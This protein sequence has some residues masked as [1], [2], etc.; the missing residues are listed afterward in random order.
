MQMQS[1][2]V[3]QCCV[4]LREIDL[5]AFVLLVSKIAERIETLRCF[6]S[7]TRYALKLRIGS[8]RQRIL[9]QFLRAHVPNL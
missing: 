9:G 3:A 5:P 2:R 8:G 6:R 1:Q 4:E 7:S